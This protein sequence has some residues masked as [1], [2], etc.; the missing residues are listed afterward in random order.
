MSSDGKIYF[1]FLD[2]SNNEMIVASFMRELSFE[3]DK[4]YENWR[5]N[6]IL[7]LDNCSSHKTLKMREIFIAAGF[8]VLFTAPASYVV[9]PVEGMFALIKK[10]NMDEIK[11][12]IM[13]EIMEKKIS[14]LTNK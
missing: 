2:G 12:P 8:T 3:L 7:V 10:I 14:K 6:H 5:S 4:D 9:S 1:K 13:P 11:T